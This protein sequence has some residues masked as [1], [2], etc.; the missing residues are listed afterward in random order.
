MSSIIITGA[1]RRIGK[2]L[3][4]EF[5][6]KGW[7]IILH[8]N[9]SE[10]SALALAGQIKLIGRHVFSLK[11]DLRKKDEIKKMYEK[12]KSDFEIP[13]AL[14][15]N[16]GIFPPPKPLNEID[17][18]FVDNVL[19]INLKAALWCS[20]EFSLI[21]NHDSSIVNVSSLGGREVW[22]YRMTYNVS[23]AALI[24]LTKSLAV[25]LAPKIK[26]NCVCPGSIEIPDDPAEHPLPDYSK[27]P[28]GRNGTVADVFAAV[29]FFVDC[30]NFISGQ[31]LTVDGAMHL[32]K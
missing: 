16:A 15:N 22:K 24:H 30:P 32:K 2:G 31:I 17:E 27:I 14:I 5:A 21:S 9:K 23:K 8:Y 11:A 18:D 26:V 20:R 13:V 1:G 7:D 3:A 12:I 28:A 6:K 25:E 19:N 29:Q 10:E 4:L